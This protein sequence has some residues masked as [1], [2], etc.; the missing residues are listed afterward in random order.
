MPGGKGGTGHTSKD[1]GLGDD[2]RIGQACELGF[3]AR[4]RF[5]QAK[6]WAEKRKQ[7]KGMEA[8]R[9]QG[10]RNPQEHTGRETLGGRSVQW[11]IGNE[12]GK[13]SGP[14]HGA[15]NTGLWRLYLGTF[16]CGKQ[17]CGQLVEHQEKGRV[18]QSWVCPF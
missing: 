3:L 11:V 12:A 10:V 4:G 8:A 16:E 14:D 9:A 7:K 13:Q 15:L 18:S 2:L 1:E 6:K 5:L 17:G